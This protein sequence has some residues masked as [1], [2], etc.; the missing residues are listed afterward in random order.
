MIFWVGSS[1]IV[2]FL[3]V[4]P[5]NEPRESQTSQTHTVDGQK[6]APPIKPV[7]EASPV[8]TNKQ[9]FFMVSRRCRIFPIHSMVLPKRSRNSVCDNFP[10]Q[11]SDW[12][13]WGSR[14]GGLTHFLPARGTNSNLPMCR[15]Q[16]VLT[17]AYTPFLLFYDEHVGLMHVAPGP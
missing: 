8:N 12:S 10:A 16:F 1:K 13:I 5:E 6:P 3:L 14:H 11:W 4:S 9:W 7:N 15:R 17:L 2:I